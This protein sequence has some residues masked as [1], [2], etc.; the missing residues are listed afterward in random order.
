MKTFNLFTNC[1]DVVIWSRNWESMVKD[2]CKLSLD[3]LLMC[4]VLTVYVL[5]KAISMLAT[6]IPCL[7][8]FHSVVP[9]LLTHHTPLAGRRHLK[10]QCKNNIFWRWINIQVLITS[11]VFFLLLNF[12]YRYVHCICCNK[13]EVKPY[14]IFP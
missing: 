5:E 12:F 3:K 7:H 8:L 1:K 4:Y 13:Q 6:Q 2:Y 14:Q 10:L 9:M 11:E